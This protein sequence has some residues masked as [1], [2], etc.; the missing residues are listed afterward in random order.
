MIGKRFL[1]SSL[2]GRVLLILVVPTLLIQAVM[3][4]VFFDRHWDNVARQMSRALAGEVLFIVGQMRAASGRETPPAVF[5]FEMATDIDIYFDPPGAL[6]SF[7]SSSPAFPEFTEQLRARIDEPFTVRKTDDDRIETRIALPDKVLRVE[8]PIKRLQTRTTVIL[9]L[10]MLGSSTL[11]LWIAAM[12]LRNQIRPIRKLAHA[13]DQFGRGVDMPDFRP[14]GATEVRMAS[15]AFITMRERIRRQLRTRTEMLAGISHDLRTPLTRMK[16]A[17]ALLPQQD[18]LQELKDDVQQ[19]EH[20]IAE[21][22]DF[23]RGDGGEEPQRLSVAGFVGDVVAG[24]RRHGADVSLETQQDM[25]VDLRPTAIRRLL[26][27]VID[28]ALRYGERCRIV[29][30]TTPSGCEMTFDDDGPGIPADRRDEVFQPFRRLETSRNSKTGGV[31]L[32]LTIARDVALAHGGDIT[33]GDAPSGGLRVT[34]R[35]PTMKG[36]FE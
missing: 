22:L 1:P 23:V 7:S 27:N 26:H 2:F 28:N 16:L 30:R 31:G 8:A 33:L 36:A 35:L 18:Q 10:W 15:R 32:G 6:D 21:Y 19:M 3:V 13:A 5:A 34:V 12:F 11:F 4:Y 9:M 24:Y 20:M 17:L 14:S 25:A 29:S